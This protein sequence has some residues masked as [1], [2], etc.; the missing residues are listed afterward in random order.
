MTV[1]SGKKIRAHLLVFGITS[2]LML[3]GGAGMASSFPFRAIAP[4]DA[5]PSLSF[6]NIKDNSIVTTDSLKGSPAALVFW[7]ADMDTKKERSVKTLAAVEENAAFLEQRKVKVLLV[8]AQGDSQEVMQGVVGQLSGKLPAYLDESQKAYNDLGIFVVPSVMLLDK[9][10]KVVSGIGYS[11][12][13]SE[14]LQGEVQVML[15]EK[16][17]EAMEKGLRP[18]MKEKPTEEKQSRRHL[19]MAL[20]MVKRG[21][22]DSA[23]SELQ[24]ALALE[25]KMA[26]A[27][28]QLGCLYLDKGNMAEAKAALDKAYE[29]DPD[30]LPATIC[31]ARVRA[32][33]GQVDEAVGDLQALLFRNARNADLHYALGTLL[34][35]Q[36]KF[37]D[38][39]K[40][41]RKAYELVSREVEME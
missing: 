37:T 9:D 10:G 15:G 18:E 14:R 20:V 31:D 22:A 26:E 6:K 36:Q 3:F 1:L 34:E 5:L 32:E 12:D 7:G 24:K 39:A 19:D 21:Q 8:N 35:K 16:S 23:I 13:F 4:G 40:E 33:E 25:P 41:Y 27:Q 30:Y 2:F 11:H 38:A 29:L 17:R 28:G